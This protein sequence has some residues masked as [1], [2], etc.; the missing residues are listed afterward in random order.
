MQ[1]IC[2]FF[3]AGKPI[4]K[5]STRSFRRGNKIVTT[6][7]AK[8]LEKWQRT[9]EIQAHSNK[10]LTNA[11]TGAV[12]VLIKFYLAKPK[13][14][15]RVEPSTRPD[16]DK[17]TRSVFDALKKAGVYLDDGQVISVIAQKAYA[18]ATPEGAQVEVIALEE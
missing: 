17:L 14:A 1:Q 5:G 2:S 11:Y 18:S 4:T 12:K 16:L 3:A 8:G 10:R 9:V 15:K 13:T 7:D 6:A